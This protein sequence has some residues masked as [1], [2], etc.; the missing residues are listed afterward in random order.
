MSQNP[1]VEVLKANRNLSTGDEV[2]RWEEALAE[3]A[4]KPDGAL[5]GD[6]FLVFDD[7]AVH[8]EVMWGLLHF[9]EY[10]EIVPYISALT[11]VT[12][13]LMSNARDWLRIFYARILNH[14]AYRNYLKI[15]MKSLPEPNK[16]AIRQILDD[17]AHDDYRDMELKERLRT[18]IEF[19][20]SD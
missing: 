12:P 8:F 13:S 3:L 5:L 16:Q 6:L 1:W 14:D 19:V 18:A 2:R 11:E 4:E 7:S 20:L 17:I 10:F 9:V 15:M